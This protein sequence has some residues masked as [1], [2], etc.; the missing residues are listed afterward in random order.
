MFKLTKEQIE[1]IIELYGGNEDLLNEIEK[2]LN[3]IGMANDEEDYYEIIA[4]TA[5]QVET[6]F[7]EY[8]RK[9]NSEPD[10]HLEYDIDEI[11]REEIRINHSNLINTDSSRKKY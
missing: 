5:A 4:A 1:E 11:L 9:K 2:K 7:F 3:L 8:E 10:L 6:A